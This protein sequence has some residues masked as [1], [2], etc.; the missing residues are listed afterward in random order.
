[1]ELDVSKL[2]KLLFQNLRSEF[3]NLD[4]GHMRKPDDIS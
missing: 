3:T 1:V 2:R 4:F